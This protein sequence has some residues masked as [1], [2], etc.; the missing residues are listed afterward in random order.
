[1]STVLKQRY[2]KSLLQNKGKEQSTV[3]LKSPSSFLPKAS[4][5]GE[6][7]K[8]DVLSLPLAG[9][10]CLPKGVLLP[11]YGLV[12]CCVFN[13]YFRLTCDKLDSIVSN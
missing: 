11:V 3:L 4:C 2:A 5:S 7:R 9:S 10:S 12:V 8:N 1:M 13:V 6:K